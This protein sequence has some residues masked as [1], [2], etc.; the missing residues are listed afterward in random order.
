MN[1]DEKFVLKKKWKHLRVMY[2]NVYF[3]EQRGPEKS[4]AQ[5][6]ENPVAS[7]IHVPLF[8]QGLITGHLDSFENEHTIQLKQYNVIR[9]VILKII[10]QESTALKICML[11]NLL[12]T[13]CQNMQVNMRKCIQRQRNWMENKYHHFG[14]DWYYRHRGSIYKLV[15]IDWSNLK[16]EML[17]LF[18][19]VLNNRL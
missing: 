14:T 15:M 3:T 16:N 7:G 11:Q 17:I 18:W 9:A 10:E 5:L 1:K 2:W 19:C 13:Y 6:H 12:G 8:W 4:A